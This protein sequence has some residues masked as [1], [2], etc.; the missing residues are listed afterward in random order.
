M[1]AI[2]GQARR[3][4]LVRLVEGQVGVYRPDPYVL[5]ELHR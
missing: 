1:V 4:S 3:L 5:A 2:E